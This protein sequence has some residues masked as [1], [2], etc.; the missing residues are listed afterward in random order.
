MV[1]IANNQLRNLKNSSERATQTTES[2]DR[3]DNPTIQVLEKSIPY[4]K[5]DR[6]EDVGNVCSQSS[7]DY[8]SL[9]TDVS[10]QRLKDRTVY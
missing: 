8:M 6:L 9:S 3:P 5:V 4:V 1:L 10:C 7:V 2:Q